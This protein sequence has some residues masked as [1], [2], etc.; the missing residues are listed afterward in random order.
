[1]KHRIRFCKL[2]SIVDFLSLRELAVSQYGWSE[3]KLDTRSGCPP[4]AG[5]NLSSTNGS[6]RLC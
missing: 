4:L 1:M 6:V 5:G 3:T 2:F